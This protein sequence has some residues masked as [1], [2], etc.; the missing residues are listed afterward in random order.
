MRLR[1][2]CE[3]GIRRR[4]RRLSSELVPT[5]RLRSAL[6]SL[7]ILSAV[8]RTAQR[9][10]S[11]RRTSAFRATFHTISA[12]LDSE[13]MGKSGGVGAPLPAEMHGSFVGSPSRSEGL[14]FLRMTTGEKVKIDS[15]KESVVAQED[16]ITKTEIRLASTER[17]D[18]VGTGGCTASFRGPYNGT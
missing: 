5:Q 7:V 1:N 18:L 8:F 17:K 11:K 12:Q 4:G 9:D 14:R 6:R 3:I 15:I 2:R 16:A 13:R 10:E